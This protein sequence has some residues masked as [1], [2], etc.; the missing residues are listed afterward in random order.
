MMTLS[1]YDIIICKLKFFQMNPKQHHSRYTKYTIDAV[2]LRCTRWFYLLNIG[3]RFL[4][5]ENVFEVCIASL[6]NHT[7]SAIQ[8]LSQYGGTESL[9]RKRFGSNRK[10][11]VWRSGWALQGIMRITS[12]GGG[13]KG[14]NFNGC[15]QILSS[16]YTGKKSINYMPVEAH[17]RWNSTLCWL[18]LTSPGESWLLTLFFVE[19]NW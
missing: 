18:Y 19:S 17:T 11:E 1:I 15:F 9:K 13:E 10:T 6:S 3:R 16:G 4:C 14:N 7:P 5:G 12:L 2:H 8:I